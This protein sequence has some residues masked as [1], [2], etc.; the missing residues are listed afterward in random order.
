MEI[1]RIYITVMI[2]FK[3]GVFL[4]HLEKIIKALHKN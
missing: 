3:G 2:N 1:M 4:F